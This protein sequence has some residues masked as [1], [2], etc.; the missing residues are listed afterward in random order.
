LC[1]FILGARD[2]GGLG[3]YGHGRGI[4][5]YGWSSRAVERV[6][7]GQLDG[8]LG[9]EHRG[10]G[11]NIFL[12]IDKVLAWILFSLLPTTKDKKWRGCCSRISTREG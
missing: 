3:P 10:E 4:E 7:V 11:C 2:L 12:V 9:Q 8:L 6:S 1:S 5:G